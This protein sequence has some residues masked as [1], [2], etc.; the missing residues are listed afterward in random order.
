[1]K[2]IKGIRG[3]NSL[4]N[5]YQIM[6]ASGSATF[7]RQCPS[8]RKASQVTVSLRMKMHLKHFPRPKHFSTPSAPASQILATRSASDLLAVLIVSACSS[9]SSRPSQ[10]CHQRLPQQVLPCNLSCTWSGSK[11]HHFRAIFSDA[12]QHPAR[13]TVPADAAEM[14]RSSTPWLQLDALQNRLSHAKIVFLRRHYHRR[15]GKPHPRMPSIGS[16]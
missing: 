12:P 3:F 8:L 14:G 2:S 7:L 16:I 13:S 9:C 4:S 6:I 5:A 15:A 11:C 10:P 1:M